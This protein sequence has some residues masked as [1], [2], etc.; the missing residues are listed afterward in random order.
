MASCTAHT[1]EATDCPA[2][3]RNT[4]S[5]FCVPR[6][7]SLKHGEVMARKGPGKDYPA[8]WVY[9]AE[10][11]PV[12]IVAETEEWRRIC[13][14]DGGAAWVNRSEVDGRR[15]LLNQAS[16]PTPIRQAPREQA[17]VVGLLNVQALAR[18]RKC[19]SGWCQVRVGGVQGW[20][21]TDETWGVAGTRQCR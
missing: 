13:G 1:D 10:G 16:S 5:G 3:Q 21:A 2:A 11:L 7:V 17:K 12:Q 4:P 19:V 8:E 14:P 20:M 15:T 18:I 6:W 9:H